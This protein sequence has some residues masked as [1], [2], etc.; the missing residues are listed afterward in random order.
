MN[1]ANGLSLIV[2]SYLAFSTEHHSL[3]VQSIHLKVNGTFLDSTMNN[4]V[5]P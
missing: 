5:C 2:P 1:T 4:A 3:Q